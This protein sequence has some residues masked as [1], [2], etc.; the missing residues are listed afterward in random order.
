MVRKK[1]RGSALI[2]ALFIMTL[3]AIAAMAMSVRLQQDIYR[4]RLTLTTDKL[5]LASQAVTFWAMGVLSHQPLQTDASLLIYPKSREHDY[6][7]ILTTGQIIDLQARFNLNQLVIVKSADQNNA[8]NIK[9]Q[10]AQALF[11]QLLN[12]VLSE[13]QPSVYESIV[14]ATTHWVNDNPPGQ[15]KD[16][17]TA[18]YLKQKPP[19]SPSH[20]PMVSVSEFR[21]VQ[22][23]DETLYLALQPYIS[24]LPAPTAININT[25]PLS[26]LMALGSGLNE[27]E[28]ATI[29][30]ARGEK[31]IANLNE[32]TD[33]LKTLNIPVE[34]VTIESNYFLSTAT[35]RT[36]DRELLHY[37]IL[38]RTKDLK[39]KVIVR[40]VHDSLNDL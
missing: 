11:S 37:T 20:Q 32:I 30:K 34:Q 33:L 19:Y 38:K 27:T 18:Y 24:A 4:T 9:N 31:G 25:A 16:E 40:I 35:T 13:R 26:V 10:G 29:I 7:D 17:L 3:V 14:K 22:G 28:A 8:S 39:G 12:N 15:G 1:S 23:V 21:L 5:Y 2:S 6:P 36:A